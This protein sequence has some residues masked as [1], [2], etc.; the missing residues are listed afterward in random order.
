MKEL[1]IKDLV[2]DAGQNRILKG[3]NL[4]I[5][6]GDVLALIGPNGHGKS[7]LLNALM[8]NPDYHIQEGSI[9]LDGEDIT[10]LSPDERSKRGL[11]MAFQNPPEIEGVSSMD[12][13]KLSINS[14]LDKPISL[15]E[16]YKALEEGYKKVK[17]DSNMKERSLNLGFSGGEKKRNEILQMNLLKPRLALLDEIDSGLDV[18]ALK[19]IGDNVLDL[20]KEAGTTFVIISHYEKLYERLKPNRTACII[21]GVVAVEGDGDLA[22]KVATEGYHYL[23]KEYNISIERRKTKVPLLEVCAVKDHYER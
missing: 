14:H 15:F 11:F 19:T 16:Y 20:K 9:I 4:T 7:T 18:D 2:V 12:F 3:L 17:L 5:R 10:N 1:V 13:F 22:M 23:E 6:A 21:N 8:G